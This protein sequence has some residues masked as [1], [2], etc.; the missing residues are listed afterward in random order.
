MLIA[1]QEVEDN[2]AAQAMLGDAS[3][4]QTAA[5]NAAKR[6]ETITMNQYK[7]GV[8]SYINVLIAQ[9]TRIAAENTLYNVKKRQFTSSVALIAAIG[10]QWET[11]KQTAKYRHGITGKNGAENGNEKLG[12][13]CYRI[14]D[15]SFGTDSVTY[16][17]IFKSDK[18]ENTWI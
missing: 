16:R 14:N 12:T 2:L 6:A 9:N 4:M 10:G 1:F 5:L 8:V 7:A 13:F 17:Q 18:R 15:S 11:P 3:D